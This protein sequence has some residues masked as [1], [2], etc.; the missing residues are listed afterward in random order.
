MSGDSMGTGHDA[1]AL[2][3]GY[4]TDAEAMADQTRQIQFYEKTHA[5]V[6]DTNKAMHDRF[7]SAVGE[8]KEMRDR[9][10]KLETKVK[11]LERRA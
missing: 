5:E 1:T 11:E 10:E 6:L 7:Q 3:H 2:A 9:L 8:M 4:N